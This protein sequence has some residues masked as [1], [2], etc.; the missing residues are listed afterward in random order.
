M[1]YLYVCMRC[2]NQIFSVTDGSFLKA[3]EKSEGNFWQIA[4]HTPDNLVAKS[5]L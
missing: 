4:I 3:M 5:I 1:E 2:V